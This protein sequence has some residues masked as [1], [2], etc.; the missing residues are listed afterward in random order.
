MRGVISRLSLRF[1]C[2]DGPAARRAVI[3]YL[4]A[5]AVGNLVWETLQLPLYTVWR[6]ARAAYLGFAVLHCWVGDL[7]IASV[8]LGC[9]IAIAGRSWLRSGYQRAAVAALIL[10]VAYTV[11]SEWLNV[12]VRGS[13]AYGPPMPRLPALGTGLSPLLQWVVVPLAAFAWARPRRDPQPGS[14]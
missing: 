5:S 7:L 4:L 3:R 13:W 9:G 14:P 8:S 6:T 2:H 11:F 10:G 1:R 12:T